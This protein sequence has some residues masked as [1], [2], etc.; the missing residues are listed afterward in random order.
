MPTLIRTLVDY[1]PDLLHVIAAQWDVDLTTNDRAAAAEQLAAAMARADAVAETWARLGDDERAAL[2]DLLASEGRMPFS[3]FTRRYGELS[4]MGP[5]RRER[6]KPWLEPA[7][8]TESLY[9]R[10][11]ITRTFEHAAPGVQEMVAIPLDLLELMPQPERAEPLP[12]YAI[13]RPREVPDGHPTAPDDV[14]TLLAYLLIRTV[15]ARGWLQGEPA[16]AIDRYLRRPGQPAYLALLVHLAYDLELIEDWA[17]PGGPA[18]RVNRD[19][20][21]PWLEAPRSHQLR[22]LAEAW[23]NSTTWNDLAYT[24][25]LEA[26]EWPVTPIAGRRLLVEMLTGSPP[27]HSAI[28][29]SIPRRDASSRSSSATTERWHSAGIGQ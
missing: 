23:F 9:Y 11:L 4:P 17:A 16:P 8:V 12:G 3:Q 24:P 20:A 22:S 2:L 7:G 15:D 26:D 10:G 14:A 13:E 21:R 18:T 28:V 1:D 6:E 25:G 29:R 19:V 27:G 5:A